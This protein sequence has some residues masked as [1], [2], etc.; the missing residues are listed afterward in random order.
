MNEKEPEKKYEKVVEKKK[1]KLRITRRVLLDEI[2][3][4]ISSRLLRTDTVT[5]D[6]RDTTLVVEV[7]PKE[8]WEFRWA[9]DKPLVYTRCLKP[10]EVEAINRYMEGS[11]GL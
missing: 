2:E 11:K 4:A 9:R 1:A 7:R 5:V 8:G 3:K 10:L 6:V